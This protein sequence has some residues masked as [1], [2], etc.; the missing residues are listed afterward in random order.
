[1]SYEGDPQL[2]WPI[3]REDTT[4]LESLFNAQ[5]NNTLPSRPSLALLLACRE[6]LPNVVK[7]CLEYSADPTVTGEDGLGAI[8]NAIGTADMIHEPSEIIE[9]LTLLIEQGV[10]ASARDPTKEQLRPLH[11]AVMTKN[12]SVTKFLLEKD[13]DMINLVD[14]E[15]M[16]RCIVLA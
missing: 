1:M 12:V 5:E 10:E 14:A 9:I 16:R 11:R 6:R 7:L 4:V 3:S 13:P 15:G 2:E 8:H